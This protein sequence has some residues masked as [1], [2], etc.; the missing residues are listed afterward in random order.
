MR[1][2]KLSMS[3][4]GPY[5]DLVDIDFE[6]LGKS[7]LYLIT[8]DTG[9][10]KTTIF[11]AIT[12]ALYGEASGDVREAGMLRSKYADSKTP[13]EVEFVFEYGGER[14]TVRRNPEYER[15][16]TKG[17]GFT[18]E[19]AAAELTL[20][21][22]KVITKLRDVNSKICDIIGIDRSQFTEISM[23]AQGDF[24]KLLLAS[25]DE[26]KK[27]FQKIFKTRTYY[28]LTE[29]LK[30]ES[31]KLTR[32]Y[33]NEAMSLRQYVSGIKAPEGGEYAEKLSEIIESEA[34]TR[35][36]ISLVEGF[37]EIDTAKRASLLNKRKSTDAELEKI[38]E[39]LALSESYEVARASI[40][41]AKE[42][43]RVKS[44][45][46][47]FLKAR[48]SDAKEKA[49]AIESIVAQIAKIEAEIPRYAE[50]AVGKKKLSVVEKNI[51]E[52]ESLQNENLRTGEAISD[53]LTLDRKERES[54][55]DAKEMF[56]KQK[57][58]LS[59]IDLQ[60][61]RLDS[62]K[63]EL[64]RISELEKRLFESREEYKK[65]TDAARE[66]REKHEIAH[67]TYLDEQ[68][69]VLAKTLTAGEPCPVCG[70]TSHPMP[71]KT[72]EGAPTKDEL[73]RIKENADKL[74]EKEST[75]CTVAGRLGGE[76]DGAKNT[77]LRSSAELLEI[78]SFDEIDASYK[79][80]MERMQDERIECVKD[81]RAQE[82]KMLHRDELDARIAQSEKKIT[83]LK[84][85]YE[86]RAEEI[87]KQRSEALELRVKTDALSAGL[88]FE[89]A[90]EAEKKKA[91]LVT[92]KAEISNALSTA[93]EAYDSCDKS[94]AELSAR[95]RAAEEQLKG[96]KQIDSVADKARR[97]ELR[98]EKEELDTAENEIFS[99]IEQNSSS[100]SNIRRISERV[101]KSEENLKRIR[102]LS[103]TACGNLTGKEKIS[104]EAYVQMTFFERIIS[105]SNLRLMMMTGGQYELVRRR[106]A[107]N[108]RSQSGLELDVI[109]HYN[110]SVRSIKTLSG[111][112]SFK[113]SLSLALG[114]SDEIQSSA[115]GIRLDSMFVDEGFGSLDEESLDAAMRALTS[116]AD[117][118]RIVGIISHVSALK[119]RIDKQIVV[120]KDK[121]GTSRVKI[122]TG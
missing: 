50:L 113:A 116:L 68:A 37:I 33:E 94:I 89:S 51:L 76:V 74:T 17:D 111:G 48:L 101:A 16:K 85:G 23:I 122:I 75:A 7:G 49:L 60:I 54:L 105:R 31:S 97:T 19:K 83:E 56:E 108:N 30:S 40:L 120:T 21:D 93:T 66:A 4:F 72:C 53:A 118:E 12:F 20:P 11:D 57:S 45:E 104:F 24:L 103:N 43:I 10:G 5:A 115:G 2:I 63:A 88:T 41:S 9:A 119:D 59:E 18:S 52:S 26:R 90:E 39:R 14:Y 99:R 6:L 91:A 71:A 38:A 46:L 112:E 67:R 25:T 1:P 78:K 117:G 110:G 87:L 107:E 34:V 3:A 61:G 44:E 42:E 96:A 114:L 58:K 65:C 82:K 80:R 15:P 36:V 70:S 102:L 81:L 92:V 77:L 8:G 73:L 27:I 28:L 13:T 79:T 69:G 64:E 121:C 84:D 100:L 109:D 29:R 47:L 32:E 22:G 106:E 35:D 62:V 55:A 98:T 86:K 95:L